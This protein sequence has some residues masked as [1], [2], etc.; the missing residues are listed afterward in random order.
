[1]QRESRVPRRLGLGAE[2]VE[3]DVAVRPPALTGTTFSPAICAL[4]GLVPCA[5]VGIRQ[6]SRCASP[7][8]A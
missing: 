3:I 7:R 8:L 4:A 5:E 6:T 1:M 2:V